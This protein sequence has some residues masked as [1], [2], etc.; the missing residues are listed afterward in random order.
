MAEEEKKTAVKKAPA[1][2]AAV[3]KTAAKKAAE[4]KKEEAVKA[5]TPAVE[6]V[7]P[8]EAKKPAAKKAAPKKE[9]A[10]EVPAFKFRK[11]TIRDYEIIKGPHITEKTQALQ[12]QQNKMTFVVADDA[13]ATEVKEAVQAIFGVKVDKV[14]T[15][16]VRAKAKRAM[17]Y[18]GHV[19]GFKKAIVKI[20]KDY[21]LGEIAKATQADQGK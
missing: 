17:R 18:Q 13:T 14:N 16:N 9:K 4:P 6:A 20:N 11:P 21:N 3:K 8:A 1:K 15:M 7:K 10:P 19:P 2:K 12:A 5:E